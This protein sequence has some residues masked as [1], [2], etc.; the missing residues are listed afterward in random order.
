MVA[1]AWLGC[2]RDDSPDTTTTPP[3]TADADK[4]CVTL[5]K[6]CGDKGKHVDKIVDQCKLA[7]KK[8]RDKGCTDKVNAAYDCYER[9]LCG[10]AD[11]VWTMADL[12]V[13][14]ERHKKCVAETNAVRS[15]VG[16]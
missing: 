14:A 13:L 4:R 1:C 6:L 7:A 9:D 16:E 10:K 15:C 12:G 3:P 2:G 5:A 8:E 11:K